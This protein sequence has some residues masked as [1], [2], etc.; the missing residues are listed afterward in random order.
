MTAARRLLCVIAMVLA[1][2]AVLATASTERASSSRRFRH[3]HHQLFRHHRHHRRSVGVGPSKESCDQLKPSVVCELQVQLYANFGEFFEEFDLYS[4]NS[5][6]SNFFTSI[7]QSAK[8]KSVEGNLLPDADTEEE[9]LENGEKSLTLFVPST[10]LSFTIEAKPFFK[11]VSKECFY[12]LSSKSTGLDLTCPGH[13]SLYETVA[14]ALSD[15]VR[16]HRLIE[17]SY[18]AAAENGHFEADRKEELFEQFFGGKLTLTAESSA[19]KSSAC[20]RVRTLLKRSQREVLRTAASAA[21]RQSAAVSA[22]FE[23]TNAFV[24]LFTSDTPVDALTKLS[25]LWNGAKKKNACKDLNCATVSK[26]APCALPRISF[27]GMLVVDSTKDSSAEELV[28]DCPL[29]QKLDAVRELFDA[30]QKMIV[31]LLQPYVTARKVEFFDEPLTQELAEIYMRH[32]FELRVQEIVFRTPSMNGDYLRRDMRDC[33]LE[34]VVALE[35]AGEFTRADVRDEVLAELRLSEWDK[36]KIMQNILA[37]LVGRK[38]DEDE[39]VTSSKMALVRAKL[40]RLVQLLRADEVQTVIRNLASSSDFARWLTRLYDF[41]DTIID[42]WFLAGLGNIS[43]DSLVP[44]MAFALAQNNQFD[45]SSFESDYL[46]AKP[47]T[48]R[49]GLVLDRGT[50]LI[51]E[52]H[53]YS[54]VKALEK[55]E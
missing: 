44:A 36:S 10:E 29:R 23:T 39:E 21:L 27:N 11:E 42:A 38:K 14:L 40:G 55:G 4:T 26:G 6:Q 3:H 2:L 31:S 35:K 8:V 51:R 33:A 32:A 48:D 54:A 7:I 1:T 41:D 53:V 50:R 13:G 12:K 15:V 52:T 30:N 9:C 22:L 18:M 45:A 37:D 17:A 49:E 16:S 34:A 28:A 20:D 19:A 24:N 46:I 43:A 47:F 25:E 5:R